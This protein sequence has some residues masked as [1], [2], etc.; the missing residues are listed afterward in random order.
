M[1]RRT[2]QGAVN[3]ISG[4]SPLNQEN[5]EYLVN[6]VEQCFAEGSPRA[7]FDM[8]EV[9]LIDGAGLEKLLDI[10]ELFESRSG[11]LKISGPNAL[12]RDILTV[13]GVANQ[14]EIFRELKAAVGS[15]LH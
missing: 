1:F 4:N 2:R 13:T 8:Q 12:C 15:F 11:T 10:Q 14:F 5:A 7:V 3:V 6:A 9:P